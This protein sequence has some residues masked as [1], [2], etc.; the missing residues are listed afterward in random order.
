MTALVAMLREI[1]RQEGPIG[2]DRYMALALGH[3]VHGYYMTR[4]PLGA[5]GDF[6][7]AP[8]ISQMFG[9]LLGLWAAEIWAAM[10]RPDRV[11][12]VE[13]GPG[14]GTLMADALRAARVRPDFAAALSVHLVETSPVLRQRQRSTLAQSGVPVAWHAALSGVPPGAAIVLANEFLDALPIRQFVRE[15]DGWHE[16]LIGLGAEDAFVFGLAALPDRE[17]AASGGI[18]DVVEIAA[19]ALSTAREIALRLAAEGG[20]AL[21]IDYGRSRSAAGATLQAVRGHHPVDPLAAPGE[22]DLTA[23]IDF[24]AIGRAASRAGAIV[25]GPAGQGEFLRA[26]GINLR[27][28]SLKQ[29]RAPADV[30]AVDAAVARLTGSRD[31]EMGALFKVLGLSGPDLAALPGLVAAAEAGTGPARGDFPVLEPAGSAC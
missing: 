8:E 3:P 15:D 19:A 12:L 4:D 20:A 26:L 5:A 16:R 22:A 27:A 23:H 30:A 18:G 2:I 7:T 24:E 25:H 10:G 6:T 11:A 13:L 28:E 17:I 14:R 31:G 9:E 29:G 21:V 1:I